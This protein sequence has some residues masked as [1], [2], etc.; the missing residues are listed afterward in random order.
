MKKFAALLTAA[1]LL[2]AAMTSCGTET[3]SGDTPVTAKTITLNGDT[4]TSDSASV[5]V[6]ENGVVTINSHG[7]YLIS[8]TLNDGMIEVNS[9][10]AGTVE[11]ILDNVN[12]TNNDG[13]CIAFVKASE[14]VVTLKD[15]SSN[16]LTDGA[17]YAFPTPDTDEPNAALYSK[18]DLTIQ[19]AGSLIIDANYETAIN[20]KDGLKIN[21][22]SFDITSDGHGIKGKDYLVI[23]DGSFKINAIGDGVKSTNYESELVGY[24]DINGGTFEIYSEDEA[25]QAISSVNFNGGSLTINSMNNGVKCSGTINFNGGTLVLDAQDNALDASEITLNPAADVTINGVPYK[26]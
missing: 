20:S 12:I 26:G 21:G 9:V 24:V 23:N 13:A 1:L 8:G 6:G 18:E 2:S 4:V 15:G 11:L 17:K 19:G 3:A 14:A 22:G 7:T 25:V 10:D 5:S 16:T